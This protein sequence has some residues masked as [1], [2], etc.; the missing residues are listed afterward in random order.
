M[1]PITIAILGMQALQAF[2]G[3]AAI[4]A[5]AKY[6]DAMSQI[7]QRRAKM[8]EQDAIK[9][10]GIE[11]NKYRQRVAKLAG[12]QQ[13]GFAGQGVDVTSGSAAAIVDETFELGEEDAQAIQTNVF[14]QALG[15]GMQATDY[16][17]NR[18]MNNAAARTRQ[19]G[20]ILGGAVD[21]GRFALDAWG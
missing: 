17:A 12:Q 2:S 10:G 7:N 18:I 14:R 16:E 20:T 8:Q 6:Q 3:S 19:A 11:A 21:A 15:Y 4:G 5:Q 1:D 9:R 13:A